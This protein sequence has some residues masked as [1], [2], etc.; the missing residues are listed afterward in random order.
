[1]IGDNLWEFPC[2]GCGS[3]DR[4]FQKIVD[5]DRMLG[6]LPEHITIGALEIKPVP[7]VEANKDRKS[8]V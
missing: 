6:R 8:V 7:V 1:M 4:V 2:P 3:T 5:E